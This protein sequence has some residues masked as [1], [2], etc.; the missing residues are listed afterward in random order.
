MAIQRL[1]AQLQAP[2][3][4]R[5]LADGEPSKGD[6]LRAVRADILEDP[7][8]RAEL[9]DGWEAVL[10]RADQARSFIDPRVPLIQARV[11][12]AD[13]EIRAMIAVL[14]DSLPVPA[15][16]I[17]IART[18]LTDGTGPLYNTHNR[19]DVRTA[20]REAIHHLTR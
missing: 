17:A 10:E 13:N 16:G 3:L 19:R 20:V 15:R 6:W 7:A 18:L 9:A 1:L 2:R 12:A 11:R 4:D 8:T 5:Q 14:R